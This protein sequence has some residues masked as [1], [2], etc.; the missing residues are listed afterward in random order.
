MKVSSSVAKPFFRRMLPQSEQVNLQFDAVLGECKHV[1]SGYLKCIKYNRGTN[2]EACRR[3][4]KDYLACRMDKYVNPY[5]N[6]QSRKRRHLFKD[7][8]LEGYILNGVPSI[9]RNLMAPD[10]FENLG[11][12]F[13]D[14]QQQSKTLGAD[15]ATSGTEKKS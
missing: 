8:S 4:A 9:Y 1:I 5:P 10:N 3:L 13:K 11:L 12:V 6:F 15:T 14:S 7:R 2:D